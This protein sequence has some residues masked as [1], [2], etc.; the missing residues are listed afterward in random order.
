MEKRGNDLAMCSENH[1]QQHQV[2]Q[3]PSDIVVTQQ[4]FLDQLKSI[5][6]KGMP[7]NGSPDRNQLQAGSS[8]MDSFMLISADGGGSN[9][10]L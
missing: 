2:S 1:H 10:L 3:N 8:A 6:Y 5:G 7:S 9:E 4:S